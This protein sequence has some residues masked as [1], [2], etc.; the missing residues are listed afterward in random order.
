MATQTGKLA[1][2]YCGKRLPLQVLQSNAGF[3]IGTADDDG[4]C[5]RE[6]VQYWPERAHAV[7]SLSSGN[8]TQ[9]Q[10]P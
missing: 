9:K 8:W 6:S 4:P 2:E 5:S 3:Y 10:E 1:L 7:E